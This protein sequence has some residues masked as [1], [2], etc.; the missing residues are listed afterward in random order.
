MKN[1]IYIKILEIGFVLVLIYVNISNISFFD[2]LNLDK[3]WTVLLPLP[4][5]L[6]TL[7]SL[8][9]YTLEISFL[10]NIIIFNMKINSLAIL[11]KFF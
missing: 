10:K 11:L 9:L 2:F 4:S 6:T 1:F 3:F 5:I 7:F 8:A